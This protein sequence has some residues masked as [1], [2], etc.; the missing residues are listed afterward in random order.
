MANNA[1]FVRRRIQG[2][3]TIYSRSRRFGT[4]ELQS[5]SSIDLIQSFVANLLVPVPVIVQQLMTS[6]PR[7]LNLLETFHHLTQQ[8]TRIT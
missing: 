4:K 2:I 1:I 7:L 5:V 8:T 3:R 6:S